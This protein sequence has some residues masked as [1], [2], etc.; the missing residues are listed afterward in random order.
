MIIEMEPNV[1]TQPCQITLA[2]A[3]NHDR[4]ATEAQSSPRADA[5][6][7]RNGTSVKHKGNHQR[8]GRFAASKTTHFLA[9]AISRR[10]CRRGP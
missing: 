9:Y 6:P 8:L 1:D 5:L 4:R 7:E 2:A 10:P 3:T